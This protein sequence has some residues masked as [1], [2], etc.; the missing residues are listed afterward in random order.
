MVLS[1]MLSNPQVTKETVEEQ[2]LANVVVLTQHIHQ[3]RLSKTTWTN[4]EEIVI[5]RLYLGDE[6]GLIDIVVVREA[7]ILP[8][9]HSVGDSLRFVVDHVL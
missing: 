4:E 8:V 7:H 5:R 6:A 9:L 3:Q 1:G 2:S